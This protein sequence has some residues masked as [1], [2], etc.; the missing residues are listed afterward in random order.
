MARVFVC[1]G[2]TWMACPSTSRWQRG[3]YPHV[4]ELWQQHCTRVPVIALAIRVQ[5]GEAAIQYGAS[6][7]LRKLLHLSMLV[8]ALTQ[9]DR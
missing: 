2:M 9:R 6:Q 1:S 7:Y 4:P 5:L 8:M 3:P